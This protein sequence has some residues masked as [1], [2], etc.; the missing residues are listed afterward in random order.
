MFHSFS[1]MHTSCLGII[2]IHESGAGTTGRGEW[3]GREDERSK[4]GEGMTGVT[5]GSGCWNVGGGECMTGVN[6]GS[7]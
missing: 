2:P 4:R 7:G 3:M 1:S 5:E 6:E